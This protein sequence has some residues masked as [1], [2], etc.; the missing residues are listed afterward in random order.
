MIKRTLYFGNPSYLS[1]SDAQLVLRY[2]EIEKSEA[3]TREE[4][5]E[6]I[7]KVPI[8]DIGIVVLDHK[9]ITITQALIDAMLGNNVALVTCDTNHHPKG[10]LLPLAGNSIQTER[11]R[12]QI[13][14]S[15]PVKKQLWAQT[16]AQKIKNQS[17]HFGFLELD[18]SYFN[19]IIKN[20]KSGDTDNKEA[21]AAAY[22]WGNFFKSK[23]FVVFKNLDSFKRYREGQPPNQYFNYGYAILRAT[24][25]RSI[26]GAGLLPTLG[27]FHKN[28]Y[29]AYC[30]ADDLIEPYRPFVDKLVGELIREFGIKEDLPKEVKAKLLQVPAMDVLLDGM[31]SPLMNATERTAVSLVRCFSG[32]QRKLLY[33]EFI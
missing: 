14:A 18:T 33:P 13:E 15:E 3:K 22:Y 31:K 19:A 8:E 5:N 7:R 20:V 17:A 23:R 2:P 4:K 11:F 30:L 25:A 9:Q 21:T 12:H 16:V 28:R 1:L 29:N 24:M 6:F 32:E 10:L 26:V 27:I